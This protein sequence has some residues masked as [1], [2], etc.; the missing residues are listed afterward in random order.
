VPL[1]EPVDLAQR[2]HLGIPHQL[3]SRVPSLFIWSAIPVSVR[4]ADARS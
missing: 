2:A 1:R 3:R 4:C